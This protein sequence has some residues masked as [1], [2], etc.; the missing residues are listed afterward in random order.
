[1]ND[2]PPLVEEVDPT[3]DE[4]REC[5]APARPRDPDPDDPVDSRQRLGTGR[6]LQRRVREA[7]ANRRSIGITA[8]DATLDDLLTGRQTLPLVGWLSGLRRA[9]ARA[10]PNC[11]PA[12]ISPIQPTDAY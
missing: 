12:S 9:D 7:P 3:L 8:Q 10:R 6:R 4:I 1:M 2:G 11:S 5:A